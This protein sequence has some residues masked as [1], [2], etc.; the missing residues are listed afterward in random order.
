[1]Q[2]LLP[3]I[4]GASICLF[5]ILNAFA[6]FSQLQAKKIQTWSA[7]LMIA[8]GLLLIMS[9]VLLFWESS[10]A[11]FTLAIGLITIQFLTINN[12]FHLYGKIN[13]GHHLLRL[14]ISVV[15]FGLAVWSLK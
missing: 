10:L 4:L 12:G 7:W 5:G 9:G 15:L 6:G 8:S 2:H 13:P 14:V 11:L 3:F 1:M